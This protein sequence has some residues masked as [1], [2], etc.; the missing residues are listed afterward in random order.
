MK[1]KSDILGANKF[2]PR[3]FCI[4]YKTVQVDL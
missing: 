4:Q 1:Y 3:W 2:D